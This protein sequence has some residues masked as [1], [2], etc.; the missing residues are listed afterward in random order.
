[1]PAPQFPLYQPLYR[2]L[3]QVLLPLLVGFCFLVSGSPWGRLANQVQA[4]G[5]SIIMIEV[6]PERPS[7]RLQR[8]AV[9]LRNPDPQAQYR[10]EETRFAYAAERAVSLVEHRRRHGGPPVGERAPPA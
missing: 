8:A 7:F 9:H 5:Q 10:L 2:R 4:N 6:E 1:M 3:L